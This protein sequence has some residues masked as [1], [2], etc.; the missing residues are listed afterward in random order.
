LSQEAITYLNE[1]LDLL[2]HHS[3]KRSTIKWDVLRSELLSCVQN[4]QTTAE[5]YPL[6]RKAL[7]SLGDHHSFFLAPDEVS[8]FEE[9]VFK[10]VGL[11]AVY[12]QGTIVQVYEGSPAAQAGVQAGDRLEAINHVPIA[13]LGIEAFK[14]S[15]QESACVTLTLKRKVHQRSYTV[16]LAAVK[17]PL[18]AKPQGGRLPQ[19]VGYLDL[20]GIVGSDEMLSA[21][22]A[23]LQDL[24]R[25]LDQAFLRGWVVDLRRN[26]GGNM[27]PMLT[28]LGPILGEGELGAFVD[29]DG[30]AMPWKYHNGQIHIGEWAGVKY[31]TPYVLKQL[32]QPVAVLSS[33]LTASSGELVLLAF[34]GRAQTRVFGEETAGV[35][36]A[37]QGMKLKDG[38]MI[39]LTIALGADRTGKTYDSPLA[40]DT[41]IEPD[42]T[43]FGTERDPVLAAALEWLHERSQ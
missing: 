18:V 7:A 1:A 37:N 27:I 13:R 10:N 34:Y 5:T 19:Q 31:E 43:Q 26:T 40:P 35:P 41:Y 33:C 39:H 36:T 24:I 38:A 32:H 11:L 3:V 28:G 17:Y 22:T 12:P 2:E 15:L 30:R 20:P 8:R 9:G 25:E 6:I 29:P 42:W 4:M 23:M 16:T 21:Y 14:G